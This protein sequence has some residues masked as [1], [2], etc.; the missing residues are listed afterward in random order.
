M[1]D[2]NIKRY[3]EVVEKINV[4]HKELDVEIA[5]F[6]DGGHSFEECYSHLIEELVCRR[7]LKHC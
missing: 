4:V 5:N 1:I 6:Y 3:C 7:S 2:E